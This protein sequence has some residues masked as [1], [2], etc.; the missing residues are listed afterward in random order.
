[1]F[2]K[3]MVKGKGEKFLNENQDLSMLPR[4]A[5]KDETTAVHQCQ[6]FVKWLDYF[7]F[8]SQTP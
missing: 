3:Y 6:Q 2:S 1:M 5:A 8:P 4:T 7:F